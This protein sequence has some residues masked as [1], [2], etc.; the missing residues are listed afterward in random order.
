MSHYKENDSKSQKEAYLNEYKGHLFEFLLARLIA[1]DA[2]VE[3]NFFSQIHP[4]L[5]KRFKTY[6]AEIRKLDSELLKALPKLSREA[7]S[8][9]KKELPREIRQ[10]HV[11]GKLMGASQNS[12]LGESDLV[13]VSKEKVLP[14][15]LK[16][17]RFGAFVNTKSGGIKS[18]IKK[19]FS[20]FDEALFM[21]NNLNLKIDAFFNALISELT[22]INQLET[23]I[24]FKDAWRKKGLSE[25]PGE[26]SKKNRER[27]YQ[28][29]N[30]II[31]ELYKSLEKFKNENSEVFKH[32]LKPLLGFSHDDMWRVICF[33]KN[34]LRCP[35]NFSGLNLTRAD[36][37]DKLKLVLH[38]PKED[39]SSFVLK[40]SKFEFQIRVKPMNKFT[41]PALKVNCSVRFL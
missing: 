6:E 32:V 29:Y 5:L 24:P 25:L 34:E 18:F 16:L 28:Y 2:L 31:N 33:Y 1:R 8:N 7:F 37:L 17:C 3:K 36:E 19:Y 13:L 9:L 12:S 20:D 40:T 26:L 14:L 38:P 35:Y 10:V 22:E 4:S 30:E 11:L 27:I 23:S 15:S 41:A 39:L 21:Q